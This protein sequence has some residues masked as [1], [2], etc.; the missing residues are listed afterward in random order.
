M[1]NYTA[2]PGD[3][4][5]KIN[6]LLPGDV[7]TLNAGSYGSLSFG[8]NGS[9]AN[10]IKIL[11]LIDSSG[12]P[13]PQ[14]SGTI[15]ITGSYLHI[16]GIN[17]IAAS[18]TAINVN[19]G[20]HVKF[21]N[22]GLSGGAGPAV[23]IHNNSHHICFWGFE[24]YTPTGTTFSQG[25]R[26]G[27][28]SAS[29]ANVN[30]P[31]RTNNVHVFDG[32]TFKIP[33]WG[34]QV[35]EGAH[36]VVVEDV[37]VDAGDSG[38]LPAVGA[39]GGDGSFFSRGDNVQLIRCWSTGPKVNYFKCDRVTVGGV[40]YGLRQ[41]I[42]GGGGRPHAD[43]GTEGQQWYA[44]VASNTD[45]L[46]VYDV[47]FNV[48]K[49]VFPPYDDTGG[50]WTTHG[51]WIAPGQLFKRMEIAGPA[52]NYRLPDEILPYGQ[53]YAM[54]DIYWT[55]IGGAADQTIVAQ[56]YGTCFTVTEA[57]GW[58][59]GFAYYRLNSNVAPTIARL[60][61]ME[62][63]DDWSLQRREGGEGPNAPLQED[64]PSLNDWADAMLVWVEVYFNWMA[65]DP[66]TQTLRFERPI[67]ETTVNLP[68]SSRT[69]P[70]W[71]FNYIPTPYPL[72]KYYQYNA[73]FYFPENKVP[74]NTPGWSVGLLFFDFWGRSYGANGFKSGP[75]QVLTT[76]ITG[77]IA[78]DASVSNLDNR[79]GNICNRRTASPS[80][81]G[82]ASNNQNLPLPGEVITPPFVGA[83]GGAAY[84]LVPIVS[85]ARVIP[86]TITVTPDMDLQAILDTRIPGDT[87]I[88]SGTH[89]GE[90]TMR[91][92]GSVTK[93]IHIKGDGTARVRYRFGQMSFL[94]A[95]HVK[96]SYLWLSNIIF[97]QGRHGVLIENAS[98]SVRVE[99]CVA[100]F[101]RDEG[102]V[103]QEDS[104][105][106]CFVGCSTTDTGIGKIEGSGFRVGRPAGA[107]IED[108][109]PDNTHRVLI[110]SC[111][112]VR[113][114][115]SGITCCDG[116]T[117][118]LVK[119]CSVDHSQ[120]NTPPVT[121]VDG[122][123][124]YFSRADRIQFISCTAIGAP[125]AGFQL[126]D[127]EWYPNDTDFGRL[128]EVK[129]GSSTGHGDAGV[130]SQSE[131]LKVYVDFTGTPPPR[132]REIEGGWSAAG[133][134]V[135]VTG[136]RELGFDSAAQ[137]FP[138]NE[139]E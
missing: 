86:E 50:T 20:S 96:A 45:D 35:C 55:G 27:T 4:Q 111:T 88:I 122:A 83:F 68:A 58:L 120:G 76:R 40:T 39:A 54:H 132:I 135:A 112:V 2:G 38:D 103:A 118:I 63:N 134:S 22:C 59:V 71:V 139:T 87:V 61:R 18:T 90:Y 51:G 47:F 85:F 105:D 36:H 48:F 25:V 19:N 121:N 65:A 37:S 44:P 113:A 102:F 43:L 93:P 64:F 23:W 12:T 127:S 10:E 133:G 129:G 24:I 66:R 81:I 138:P 17:V 26:V 114:Y 124:G 115:G 62:F 33:G 99:N 123:H 98:V 79:P 16:E 1:T 60:Y 126:Y 107:W 21:R 7:L 130:V 8:V 69:T 94:P 104:V 14:L 5:S 70:G 80:T 75:L 28:P 78:G 29:W 106:V 136:F 109:H 84:A 42:K 117:E 15:T 73:S 131:G 72:I 13:G 67:V 128:I 3:A 11:G 6:A 32:Q 89:R 116:A 125:G 77:Q 31:D 9:L 95:F 100:Q 34:V 46:K 108:A 49:V 91:Q 82:N 137:N 30:T 53:V 74:T 101:V 57:G 41:E 52:S 119:S 97:E 110:Q 92:S 56:T